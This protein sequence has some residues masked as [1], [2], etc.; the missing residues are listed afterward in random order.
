MI[1]IITAA[2]LLCSIL[3]QMASCQNSIDAISNIDQQLKEGKTTITKIL[4]SDSLMYL[5][6]LT[7][8]R[9]V[10]KANA[11]AE[12]IKIVTDKEPGTRITVTGLVVNKKGEP[13]KNVLMYFY[14]T[15]DR[16]W[17]SDTGVHV[18]TNSGDFKHARLFGYLKTNDKGEFSF[19]TIRPN[20]YPGSDFAGHIHLQFWN[21]NMKSLH[22]PGE[23]QFDEDPRMTPERKARSLADG[24]LV[25]KNTGTAENMVYVFKVVVG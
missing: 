17:Y 18:L 19:E 13:Q 12:K 20:G 15:D 5:H 7:P 8:F 6:S 3:P 22:G 25:T 16:G 24:F 10:I 21:G 1:K 4:S 2:F 14:H 23:F 11:K 9:E